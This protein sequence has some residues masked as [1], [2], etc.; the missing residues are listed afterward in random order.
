MAGS[1]ITLD[2]LIAEE[3][4]S[5]KPITFEDVLNDTPTETAYSAPQTIG[6]RMGAPPNIS[7]RPVVQPAQD[8][9]FGAAFKAGLV[10]DP[11]TQDR[12]VAQSVFPNDPN[13]AARIGKVGGRMVKVNDQGQLEY[14]TGSGGEFGAGLL[15]NSPEMLLGGVGAVSPMP[16]LGST[17]GV[18]G[19]RGLKNAFAGV[20]FDEPQTI[21]GN[22]MDVGKQGAL[23]AGIGLAT[24]GTV[25]LL[26]RGRSVNLAPADMA[27]AQATQ[28]AVKQ[29]FGIDLNLA[30]A[31]DD[32]LLKQMWNYLAQYPGKSQGIARAAQLLNEGQVD[33]AVREFISTTGRGYPS[34]I[35]GKQAMDVS[36][37]AIK[38]AKTQLQDRVRPLYEA[39][40]AEVPEV[41]NPRLVGLLN[42]PFA[43][44]AL[45]DARRLAAAEGYKYPAGKMDLRLLDYTKQAMDDMI[46]AAAKNPNQQRIIAGQREQLIKFLDNVSGAKYKAARAA[47]EDGMRGTIAPMENGIV[48]V[49][50]RTTDPKA[51]TVAVK[52]FSDANVTPREILQAKGVILKQ[53][54]GAAAWDGLV[55]QYLSRQWT[56]AN[57][58]S[59][60]G[61]AINPA[62]KFT[63][64]VAATDTNMANL[65]AALGPERGAVVKDLVEALRRVASTPVGNSAT[66][67]NSLLTRAFSGPAA[68][69][70]R[71][72]TAPRQTVT[73]AADQKAIQELTERVATAMTDPT[74][75]NQLKTVLKMP[76]ST[77]KWFYLSGL[78]GLE[79]T[80][81]A[82]GNRVAPGADR[83]PSAPTQPQAQ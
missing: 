30:A 33:A 59:Q 49:L 45:N 41:T 82:A 74:K 12:V 28:A 22:L 5:Q 32:P 65:M 21:G 9:N 75:V 80:S 53:E 26:N 40:Y 68:K 35:L 78:L 23:N 6:F 38:Q 58:T 39:A 55:R 69:T 18:M 52:V 13:G 25:G 47:Y 16:V 14:V 50:A 15:A 37:G 81:A 66:E 76:D 31:S 4:P 61:S 62:G 51:A 7:E 8:S 48:G 56:L 2:D 17:L 10:R 77:R 42:R 57:K 1:S 34:A 43:E 3:A 19:A 20:V 67:F 27:Q 63:Q 73:N 79:T 60:T 54:G 64:N 70:I 24:K 11:A 46:E 44:K 36:R 71:A 29:K 83:M 72:I